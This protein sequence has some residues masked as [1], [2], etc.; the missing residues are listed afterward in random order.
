ML[1]NDFGVEISPTFAAVLFG[2]LLGLV[3][4][5][6]AQASRFCLRRGLVSG[7]ERKAALGV[8][9]FALIFALLVTQLGSILGWIDLSGHRFSQSA[10]PVA[11]AIVGGLSFGVGMVLTRGCVS[12]LTVLCGSGNL[13]AFFVLLIFAIVAHATLKGVLAPVRVAI[14]SLTV[15]LG[16]GATAHGFPGGVALWTALLGVLLLNQVVRSGASNGHLALAGLIGLLVPLGWFG[17]GVF[18]FDDFDPIPLETLSFTAP[19]ANTL[20]WSVASTSIPAGFGTGLIGGVIV[21]AGASAL[22]RREAKLVSFESPRQ[23]LRYLA[24]GTLMGFGGVLA[25]GCT[26]GAGLSGVSSL[27]VAAIIALLSMIGGAVAMDRV[28]RRSNWVQGSVGVTPAE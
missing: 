18:L 8:W 21:G 2:A 3:F 17:T 23:T 28:L 24:G 19:W 20:F 13:R 25:G 5:V 1:F 14:G 16:S 15:D 22:Y 9:L 4:G 10:V 6:A 12:R 7:P 26:I 27:S 11:A